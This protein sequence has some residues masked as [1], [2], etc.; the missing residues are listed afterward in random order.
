MISFPGFQVCWFRT[1]SSFGRYCAARPLFREQHTDDMSEAE[2][3]TL[4]ESCLRACVMR[5]KSMINKFQVAKVGRCTLTPR[6]PYLKG[7]WYP[8]G[9]NS[10]ADQVKSRFQTLPSNSTCTATPR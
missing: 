8:G 3:R 4:I 5:D 10:C 2:A 9:F 1:V 7:A 6:D